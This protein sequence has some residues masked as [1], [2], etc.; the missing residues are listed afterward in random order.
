MR[1]LVS[2]IRSWI[3]A[4]LAVP[5]VAGVVSAQST[6]RGR[7]VGPADEAIAGVTVILHRVGEAGGREIGR[8]ESDGEG[9]FSVEFEHEGGEG[10][11]FA[12]TRYEDQLYVGAFFRDPSEVTGEYVL[13]VG[14]NPMP[15]GGA[16]IPPGPR[17]EGKFPWIG[18]VIGTAAAA[19]VIL[20]LRG[21]KRRPLA[22]RAILA[23]LAELEERG[24]G[25]EESRNRR[26]ELRT[27][28]RGPSALA[29]QDAADPH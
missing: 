10:V 18:L 25:G 8:S 21:A 29:V 6:L 5:L 20:P 12:A 24:D 26:D 19:A 9:R 3:L 4:T 1:P 14:V 23:E 15:G 17:P 27:R 28:L 13:R 7:V 22:T 16:A 2:K 11:Y